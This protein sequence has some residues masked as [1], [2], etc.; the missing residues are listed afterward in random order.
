MYY[1]GTFNMRTLNMRTFNMKALPQI[2]PQVVADMQPGPPKLLL[3]NS[4]QIPGRSM[5]DDVMT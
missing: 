2:V 1:S 4:L 3:E 5:H